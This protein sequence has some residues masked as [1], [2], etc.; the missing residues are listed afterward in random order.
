M[1][2]RVSRNLQI[3]YLK[4]ILELT[5]QERRSLHERRLLQYEIYSG[6][7]VADMEM[8]SEVR[9]RTAGDMVSAEHTVRSRLETLKRYMEADAGSEQ[10]V[11]FEPAPAALS[12]APTEVDVPA[13][14]PPALKMIDMPAMLIVTIIGILCALVMIVFVFEGDAGRIT[15]LEEVIKQLGVKGPL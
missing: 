7:T 10:V 13:H 2:L 9:C 1:K 12:A 11:D 14:A 6:V 15:H 8:G 3:D 4:L 5:V